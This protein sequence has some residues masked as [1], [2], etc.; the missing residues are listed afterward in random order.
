MEDDQENGSGDQ[1]EAESEVESGGGEDAEDGVEMVPPA[2]PAFS[3]GALAES[4]TGRSRKPPAKRA[5]LSAPE[6]DDGDIGEIEDAGDS[7]EVWQ[8]IQSDTLLMQVAKGLGSAPNS[9]LGL[10]PSKTFEDGM[11]VGKQ[12]RG[13]FWWHYCGKMASAARVFLVQ[14]QSVSVSR[15]STGFCM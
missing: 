2:A 7:D 6:E 11:K 13:V 14:V 12:L 15:E 4:T 3:L 8:A 10:L 9:L 1:E 5:K